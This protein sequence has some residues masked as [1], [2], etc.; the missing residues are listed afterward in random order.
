MRSS[1][2][3]FDGFADFFKLITITVIALATILSLQ[4]QTVA[5]EAEAPAAR[6]IVFHSPTCSH[7]RYVLN[8]V[9]PPLQAQYGDQLQIRLYDLSE[10]EHQ[11]IYRLLHEQYPQLPNSVPQG[12]IDRY[13]LLG[14]DEFQTQ[15]PDIIS[16]CLA[17]GGSDWAFTVHDPSVNEE[18]TA[19]EDS[20]TTALNEET[21]ATTNEQMAARFSGFSFITIAA[22]GLLDGINPCAFTTII[23]F[24]SYLAL[25]GRKDRELLMVGAAFTLAV[26]LTYLA[27]GLGLST[28]IKSFGAISL[29]GKIIYAGTAL[30][31]AILAVLSLW[32]Y[33][34]IRQGKLA[35][36]AL[37][38]P[39]WL[40][41]RIH[42]TIRT[43]SRMSGY[44]AAAFVA[45]VLVSVFELAC[46]GQV[47]LPTIVFMTGVA[48]ARTSAI[49]YLILYNLMFIVPLVAIFGVTYFG[50][51]S[52]QLTKI[53]QDNA[54][55]IKLGTAAL[56]G[57]LGIWLG[58]SVMAV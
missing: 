52:Q 53:F 54:A 44:V 18:V 56:F 30:I 21:V 26:F 17:K 45:G 51:S 20:D 1:Q 39:S 34:K 37:Q 15:L 36:I 31:C 41:Q 24:V 3:D 47:Y 25:V 35:E 11:T 42:Q 8:E 43:R 9:L 29:I 22:A 38:L 32:D 33:F 23:F 10:P 28:I 50:T 55:S 46:T 13:V 4:A 16:E 2:S 40:K 14:S 19:Q 58:Y 5:Q 27:L 7:C 49:A 48:E 6:L 12:Y 57:A